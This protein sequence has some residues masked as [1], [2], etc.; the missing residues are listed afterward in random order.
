MS[1]SEMKKKETAEMKGNS[2]I[3]DNNSTIVV[4]EDVWKRQMEAQE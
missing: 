2:C 1:F 4:A 3:K